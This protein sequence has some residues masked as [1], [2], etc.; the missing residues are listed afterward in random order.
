MDRSEVVGWVLEPW[1]LVGADRP[2]E[3]LWVAVVL[4]GVLSIVTAASVVA[5]GAAIAGTIDGPVPV[6]NPEHPPEWVCDGDSASAGDVWD[7]DAPETIDRDPQVIA[8]EAVGGYVPFALAGPPLLWGLG[9]IVVFAG[10]RLAGGDPSGGG[11]A[12]LAGWVSLGEFVR[13]AVALGALWYVLSG[14]TVSPDHPEAAIET[15]R[16]VL[17]PLRG[18]LGLVSLVVLAWQWAVLTRGLARDADISGGWA[19]TVLGIPI[20]LIA[21]FTFVP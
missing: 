9:T 16:T 5:I 17:E 1:R 18:P 14:V 3:L 21:L 20:G 10:G 7:C 4:V 19:A 13:L 15:Y 6:D 8:N 12:A 11:S 2:E